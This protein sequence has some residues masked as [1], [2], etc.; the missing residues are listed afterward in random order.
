MGGGDFVICS[1][2]LCN[3]AA[4]ADG[5]ATTNRHAGQDDDVAAEPAVFADVDFLAGLGPGHAVAQR[6]VERV[7]AGVEAAVGPDEGARPDRCQARVDEDAVEVHERPRADFHVATVIHAHGAVHPR[8]RREEG[9]IFVLGDSLRW[10]FPRVFDDAGLGDRVNEKELWISG[11]LVKTVWEWLRLGTV[12]ILEG[13][14]ERR[15]KLA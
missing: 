7:C 11:V 14:K 15:G 1:T 2:H 3:Y 8:V 4:G 5:T 10:K 13:E 6:R 12:G 9:F